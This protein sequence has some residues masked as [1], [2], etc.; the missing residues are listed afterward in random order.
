MP[1]A[2]QQTLAYCWLHR[3]RYNYFFIWPFQLENAIK[4]FSIY[5]ALL[6]VIVLH[7]ILVAF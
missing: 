6:L 4:K 2:W 7:L 3:H 5:P 1:G